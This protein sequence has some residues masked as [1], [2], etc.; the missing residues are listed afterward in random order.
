M[1]L[2][3]L[4]PARLEL[5]EALAYYADIH[6]DLAETLFKEVI[7]SRKL[8]EQFP[9]AW[10]NMGLGVHGFI[11]RGYPYTI[12]YEVQGEDVWVI[13]YAHHKRRPGYWRD[14]LKQIPK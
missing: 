13:A 11:V 3:A 12:V 8:I 9:F 10:M 5:D 4:A 14:R 2:H 6:P 7:R 1:K